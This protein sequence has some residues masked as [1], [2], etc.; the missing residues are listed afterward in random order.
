MMLMYLIFHVRVF[1]SGEVL[2]LVHD[3]GYVYEYEYSYEY[4]WCI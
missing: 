4:L 3:M 1:W 2:T